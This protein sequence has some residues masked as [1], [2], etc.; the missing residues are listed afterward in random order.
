MAKSRR[1]N[2]NIRL[3]S[4]KNLRSKCRKY[5][6]QHGGEVKYVKA[7]HAF[8]PTDVGDDTG[9]FVSIDKDDIIVETKIM[10][11]NWAQGINI[12]KKCRKVYYPQN[13]RTEHTP[14][15]EDLIDINSCILQLKRRY[16]DP[17]NLTQRT[18][19]AQVSHDDGKL[20]QSYTALAERQNKAKRKTQAITECVEKC[21]R[22]KNECEKDINKIFAGDKP[23][24]EVLKFLSECLKPVIEP[25]DTK[26]TV[27]SVEPIRNTRSI[28]FQS[29]FNISR[30][31]C[32]T[33]SLVGLT[34]CIV[35]SNK[36]NT[37]KVS[38]YVNSSNTI[39]VR[40]FNNIVD[41]SYITKEN[42][43]KDNY[44]H[45]IIKIA[46][47]LGVVEIDDFGVNKVMSE[48]LEYSNKNKS[49]IHKG[50]YIH[51][52]FEE[53]LTHESD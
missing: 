40:Y 45:I 2:R 43:T 52:F 53:L 49:A 50:E 1:N 34:N 46:H 36:I 13:R 30:G 9:E 32:G 35:I 25:I 8:K 7:L 20:L 5:N 17:S 51:S 33:K 44:K 18:G 29:L 21:G 11:Q 3:R 27:K 4:R 41:T 10:D 14:T 24:E 31:D 47:H 48:L 12:S 39:Q 22:N 28:S 15:D 42:L 6:T 38:L 23:D 19:K 16:N 37:K 26:E